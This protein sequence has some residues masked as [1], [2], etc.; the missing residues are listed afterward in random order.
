MP[1]L[2]LEKRKA[3]KAIRKEREERIK[4]LKTNKQYEQIL[5]EYGLAVYRKHVSKEY[6]EQEI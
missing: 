5:E 1:I 4:Q 3:M 6:K 2:N